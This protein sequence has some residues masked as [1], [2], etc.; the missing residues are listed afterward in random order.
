MGISIGAAIAISAGISA[1]SAGAAAYSSS[2]ASKKA[3]AA[4]KAAGDQALAEQQ[5]QYNQSRSDLSGYQQQGQ[6]GLAEMNRLNGQMQPWTQDTPTYNPDPF[7][8]PTA[9]ENAAE[10]GVRMAQDEA[11][12]AIQQ[13]AAARGTALG[14]NTMAAL[15]DRAAGIQSQAYGDTFARAQN[16]YSTNAQQAWQAYQARYAG[17]QADKASFYEAQDRPYARAANN[18]QMGYGATGLSLGLG[19]NYANQMGNLYTQQ[20]N[21]A[22]A[23][24]IGSSNAR[25]AGYNAIGDAASAAVLGYSP[26]YM[27]YQKQRS[28][29]GKKN[30]FS[31]FPEDKTYG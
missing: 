3:A 24:I 20:G 10:P 31:G 2:Q 1:A 9:L 6:A 21:A 4:Q 22:A 7:V 23:G 13:S 11:A 8:A 25:V 30:Q 15:Q 18:A 14:G 26:D 27:A 16:T 19:Q 28:A 29:Y 17:N 5:R 12:R